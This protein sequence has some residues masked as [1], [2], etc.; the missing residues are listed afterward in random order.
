MTKILTM[1][2]RPKS[3]VSSPWNI[4]QLLHG[5]LVNS[6]TYSPEVPRTARCTIA[7]GRRPRAIVYRDVRGTEGLWFWLFT[8]HPWNNCFITQPTCNS[9]DKQVWNFNPLISVVCRNIE[10]QLICIIQTFSSDLYHFTTW[11]V[12]SFGVLVFTA[13]VRKTLGCRKY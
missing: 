8:K 7:R 11:S 1:E 10:F 3:E 5:C 6:Q 9:F 4:I 12:C 2:N 13:Y